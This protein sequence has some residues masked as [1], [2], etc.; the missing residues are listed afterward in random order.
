MKS[1]DGRPGLAPAANRLKQFRRGRAEDLARGIAAPSLTD[2]LAVRPA[3]LQRLL[4]EL[5][6]HQI[7]LDMQ[8]AEL[9]RTHVVDLERARSVDLY[10]L[11][12]V[13]SCGLGED[14]LI[15]QANRNAATLLRVSRESLVTDAD[16]VILRVN[17]AFM[18]ITG[19][20]AE[21]AIGNTP[22]MLKSARQSREFYAAMWDTLNASG[23]W[24]GDLR[25][26]RKD[27]AE[28][29]ERRSITAAKDK[30]GRVTHQVGYPV[31]TT[32][33]HLIE[34]QRLRN[35]AALRDVLVREVHHRIKN[36]L[37]G[38]LGILRRY[39]NQHPE[40]AETMH[41]AISQVQTISVIHGLQGQAVASVVPMHELTAA[42]ATEIK[43]LW[44][45]PI[46][47]AMTPELPEYAVV[48]DEAV[49][50]AMVLDELIVN[51]VKHGGHAQGGVNVCVQSGARCGAL[52]VRIANAGR[53]RTDR[54][55]DDGHRSGRHLISALLPR[56]ATPRRGPFM[57][58][59]GRH[60]GH[61]A[62]TGP[63]IFSPHV[64]DSTWQQ[65]KFPPNPGNFS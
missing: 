22:V 10:D 58:T 21:E 3:E 46:A 59:A 2:L 16:A 55:A 7:E 48:G 63:P 15:P 27:E 49:P 14:G 36:N 5:H 40:T 52:Q 41:Q 65:L 45:A 32:Q 35:E 23:S 19:F 60:S 30:H 18:K 29:H 1:T 54:T 13:E 56:Y 12:P 62:R 47:L 9:R 53:F 44:K 57:G 37:L 51:A 39:A 28:I 17:R 8:S 38:C 31:D 61:L 26:R 25:N 42:I 20:S 11:A 43:A 50:V 6:V 64:K 34:Q 24:R 33:S 4:H